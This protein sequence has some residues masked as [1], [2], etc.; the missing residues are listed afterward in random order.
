MPDVRALVKNFT[1]GQKERGL[2]SF[3]GNSARDDPIIVVMDIE[4]CGNTFIVHSLVLQCRYRPPS[5][6]HHPK[7]CL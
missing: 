2:S 4:K 7:R 3:R 5:S 6:Q 1:V